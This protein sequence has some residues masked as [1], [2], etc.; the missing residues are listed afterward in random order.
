MVDISE[1]AV[2]EFK[3][4]LNELGKENLSVK[5]ISSIN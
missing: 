2:E 4:I 1:R 3:K 5:F